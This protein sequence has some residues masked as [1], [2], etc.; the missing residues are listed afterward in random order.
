MDNVVEKEVFDFIL[1][2]IKS[3]QGITDNKQDDIIKLFIN[4]TCTE[5]VIRTNR[6]KFP[7]DLKY[8]VINMANTMYEL[9]K[10]NSDSQGSQI[11][12]SMS[13]DGRKVDFG[14]DGVTKMKLQLAIQKQ[15][16]TQ[17]TLINRYRLLYKVRCPKN[18][19]N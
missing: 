6:N 19:Q 13:E 3:S 12:Q 2:N 4:T 11:I 8:L 10:A 9:H 17:D 7:E 15:L 1:S 16:D 5:I 14:I 18:E